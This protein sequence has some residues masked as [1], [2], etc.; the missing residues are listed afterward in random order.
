MPLQPSQ[1][2]LD[3]QELRMKE[4]RLERESEAQRL[5]KLAAELQKRKAQD[6]RYQAS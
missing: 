4:A 1:T 3:R 2:T 5:K 6:V